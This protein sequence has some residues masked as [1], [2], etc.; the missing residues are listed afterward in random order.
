MLGPVVG[1]FRWPI[2]FE[3]KLSFNLSV[4]ERVSQL[5]L[6]DL[7]GPVRCYYYFGSFTFKELLTGEK[8]NLRFYKMTVLQ[9]PSDISKLETRFENKN[10]AKWNLEYIISL[11]DQYTK[12]F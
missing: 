10:C 9:R 3:Q 5:A 8:Q 4:C 6:H 7:F 12:L 2:C 1:L 11:A